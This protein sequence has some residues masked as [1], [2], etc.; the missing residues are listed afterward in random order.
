MVKQKRSSYGYHFNFRSS[1]SSILKFFPKKPSFFTVTLYI[2]I[3]LFSSS[4]LIFLFSSRNI[5]NDDHDFDEQKHIFTQYDQS[6]S[7][8]ESQS[9]PLQI[10]QDQLWDSPFSYGLHPCVKP[11]S[12]YIASK[13]SNRYITVKCNGGLNQMRTGISD[14][15]AVAHIMNA[16]L[17]IP[18]LDRRSFWQDTSKF[19]DIFDELHFIKAL[20]EDVRIVKELPKE[21]E[22]APRA[23]KHFTSWSGMGYYQEMTQLW[24]DNQVIHVAKS[25]SRLANNDLPLDIQRLR[26]RALYHSLRFSMPIE[27]LGKKLVERLRS[28]GGRYIALHLRYEKDMLSFTG[29]TYGLTNAESEELRIMRENTNHWKVKVIN[30]TEQRISGLCPLTPKEVGIFLQALGYPAST[31]IYI[32]AGGIYG[33]NAHLSELMSRFPNLVFKENLAANEELKAFTNHASQYAALDYIISIESDVFIPTHSGNMARAVE[34]HRRFLGHRKTITPDRKGL[35]KLFDRLES[36]KLRE[37]PSFSYLVQEMHKNWQG[38][39]RK[40]RG[41]LPGIKGRARFRTEE[42]FYENPY[43]EC[44]CGPKTHRAR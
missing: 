19:S 37:G 7:L 14:M 3:L 12:R 31:L 8:S 10:L 40:R 30:S 36:G 6:Q 1:S 29:C 35:V 9:Q 25:D 13:G 17:V 28:R 33:G 24:K 26:C 16:T 27:I 42:S 38:A 32:A 43:P 15:V 5:V 23:R 4:V 20:Q 11:T 18:Q 22:S 41:P 44:I 34:G 21:L 2:V 39:P